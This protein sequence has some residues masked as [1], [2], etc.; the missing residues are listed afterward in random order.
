MKSKADRLLYA[1][2]GVGDLAVDKVRSVG[3]LAD[4]KARRKT[5]NDLVKRGRSLSTRVVDS[6]PTRQA[7]A[8]TKTARAQVRAAATSVTKAARLNANAT[9]SAAAKTA[10]AS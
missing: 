6:A 10:K 1:V 8:Q 3:K 2:I 5:Y 9:K 4:P 7:M